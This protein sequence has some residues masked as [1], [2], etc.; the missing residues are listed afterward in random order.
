MITNPTQIVISV[1]AVTLIGLAS[2]KLGI[3]DSKGVIAAETVGLSIIVV[4][5]WE[6]LTILLSFLF[7]AG[8]LTKYKYEEKRKLG[9]AEEKNGV[10]G[11][12][13]VLANSAA[14]SF[15]AVAHGLVPSFKPF[16]AGFLGAVSTSMADTLATELGLLSHYEPRLITDLKRRVRAGTSGGVTLLGEVASLFGVSI[17]AFVAWAVGFINPSGVSVV[18]SLLAGFLGCTFDSLLGATVQAKY[19]CPVCGRETE[20][21]IHCGQPSLNVR[22][23]KTVDNNVVNFISTVFGASVA[24]LAHLLVSP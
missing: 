12:Q 21:K 15:F 20:N 2:R 1:I 13:N 16:S 5:G 8:I 3:M 23:N 10:R 11:W 7:I 9:V 4:G 14:A 6:F 19:K 24:F 18:I 17:I 22:G